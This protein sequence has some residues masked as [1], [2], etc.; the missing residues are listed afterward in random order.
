MLKSNKIDRICR[1]VILFAV[2]LSLA[3]ML[4]PTSVPQASA[5]YA[6]ET[7]LFD[8]S[9]VHE[10]N[11]EM[12]AWDDFI[13]TCEDE[14]YAQA[15]LVIDGT[16]F[17]NAAIRA[18]GNTSLSSVSSYG[19]DRYSFK[20]E[21]D[22]Y[23]SIDTCWG[24]D[25]LCLNN[26]IQDA[27]Y[28]KDYIAYTL[29][30]KMGVKAP[31][32]AFAWIKVNGE[33]WGLY[34]MVEGVEDSFLA[35]NGV[36]ATADLYKPDSMSF[37]GGRGNG[38]GFDAGEFFGNMDFDTEVPEIPQ[39]GM[40]PGMPQGG[41]IPQML[42][43]GN[44]V[45]E[46]PQTG[47]NPPGGMNMP[48]ASGTTERDGIFGASS[49]G[50]NFGGFGESSG[51]QSP[52]ASE[53]RFFENMPGGDFDFQKPDGGSFDFEMPGGGGFGGFSGMGG[54]DTKLIYT[55][56]DF[57]SYSNIFDSAKTTVTDADKTRLIAAI[58]RMNEG[59]VE[60]SVAIDE[61]ITYMA[62]HNF[63]VNG[64]SYT[65]SMVHNY[66][67]LEQDGILSMIP[68]DYN[69]SF[70]AFDGGRGGDATNSVNTSVDGIA[71]SD[72]PMAVWI[73]NSETYM[74]QYRETY[75]RFIETV[76][77]SGWFGD[78]L[79]RVTSLIAP[80]IEKDVNGF[81]S[82]DEYTKAVSTLE[83][84]VNA[85]VESVKAQLDGNSNPRVDASAIKVSDMGSMGGG[86]GGFGGKEGNQPP[87]MPKGGLSG[88][89]VNRSGEYLPYLIV[90]AAAL[91]IALV[92]AVKFK[93]R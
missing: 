52:D 26:L 74:E 33:D 76:F 78:E 53:S 37:G 86:K 51:T 1:A 25:K 68:W 43:G 14:Q 77:D 59:D 71:S 89:T 66:Y 81:Y 18:K 49:G 48:Q 7:R 45:P 67:L 92:F 84:Y 87:E 91:V 23:K 54:D 62:V 4:V 50:Q 15:T 93:K 69:L 60:S 10:I 29:M 65:G 46:M 80:Y 19:N 5:E 17:K 40:M 30:N 9:F 73:M 63:M 8:T 35:R 44:A 57:D 31:L 13:D 21:F 24:L 16:V 42:Q 61:V 20:V 90:T 72:R 36:K 88:E 6:Y 32:C 39:S 34:L 85:R 2:I 58:K 3:L 41:M 82:F 64:D 28:L 55:D 56:D 75:A 27:T 70:G 12:D 38:R 79:S 47:G 22:H 11:I 83:T